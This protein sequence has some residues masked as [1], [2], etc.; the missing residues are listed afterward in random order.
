MRAF[1]HTVVSV[2]ADFQVLFPADEL[3][4]SALGASY[5][6]HVLIAR[7]PLLLAIDSVSRNRRSR[8]VGQPFHLRAVCAMLGVIEPIHHHS[9]VFIE[10]HHIYGSLL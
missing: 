7:V 2:L 10:D 5:F 1:K 6:P 3:K 9:V 8:E 4:S